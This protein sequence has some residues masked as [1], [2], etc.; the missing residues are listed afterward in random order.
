MK[1]NEFA[2]ANSIIE[3]TDET[4]YR[5]GDFLIKH[6]FGKNAY[7][8]GNGGIVIIPEA[9]DDDTTVWLNDAKGI[10]ELHFSGSQKSLSSWQFGPGKIGGSDTIQRIL[11][12]EGVTKIWGDACFGDCHNLTEVVLPSSL[13]YLSH[14]AFKDSPWREENLKEID[15]CIYLDDF[16]V[17]SAKNIE[18]AVVREGTKMICG[19]AFKGRKELQS[20]NIPESVRCIGT[21]AFTGCASL[22]RIKIQGN[23]L[24]TIEDSAF[25]G[26]E[27]LE[28][29]KIP[30]SCDEI[31]S[32]AFVSNTGKKLYLPEYA[33]IPYAVSNDCNAIQKLFYAACYLTSAEDH[34]Q[35]AREQYEMLVKKSKTKLL[36][37]VIEQEHIIALRNLAPIA[38]TKKNI[39]PI[40]EK[41]QQKGSPEIIAYL[42]EFGK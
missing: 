13:E 14:N 17:S 36:D 16:L 7:Y 27:K 25:T 9:I 38:L 12:A 8:V 32:I 11:F 3:N 28:S 4:E 6:D 15:G 34:P 31:S 23:G 5:V 30:N 20:V 40:L 26:C 18:H 35:E 41:A 33:Y 21:Q 24:R 19:W 2:V 42:L 29:F 1:E 10:T 37:F 39:G 22:Q